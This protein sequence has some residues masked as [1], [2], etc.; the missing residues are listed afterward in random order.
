VQPLLGGG[1]E[2]TITYSECVFVA[3]V[4]QRTKR[5]RLIIVFGLSDS[6]IFFQ[7][8]LINGRICGKKVIIN[9]YIYI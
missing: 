9:I 6:S 4:I 7:H 2:I 8:Y 5:R 3:L 1:K